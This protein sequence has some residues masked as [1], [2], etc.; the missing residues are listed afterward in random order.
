MVN[1]IE[2]NW[3]IY[4]DDI[5]P[6]D[7][8]G[9]TSIVQNCEGT[10]IMLEGVKWSLQIQFWGID[11]LRVTDEGKRIRTYHDTETLQQYRKDFIGTPMYIVKKSEFLDWIKKVQGFTEN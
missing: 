10:K 9:V 6:V 11:S 1:G 8:Y 7:K 3:A 2:E 4:K 5:I